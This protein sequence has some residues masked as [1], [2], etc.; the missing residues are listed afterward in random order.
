VQFRLIV[1]YDG[2]GFHGW[3][4]QP[5]ERT[6]QAVL[7]SA[8]E[9]LVG[10]PVRAVAAGRTDAGVHAEGQVVSFVTSKRF[11][12]DVVRRALNANLPEDVAVRAADVVPDSF[13]A[14]HSASS[15]VYTYRIWN[16]SVPSPF[17]RRHA[18]QVFQP[19]DLD[20]MSRAAAQLIGEH[21]FSSFRAAD[22]DAAHAVRRVLHSRM[23]RDRELLCYEIEATA[24]LRHMVR[25]IVG[26]L[27]EVGRGRRSD[28]LLSLLVLRDRTRAG[29]TAPAHGLCL[30]EVRY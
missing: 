28:D 21:D 13:D 11:A 3:Q 10:H 14:R 25:N 30:R 2:G 29:A 27:A 1:E 6:V 19:L 23:T 8:I 12:P 15:R 16:R 18:W 20:A 5:D 9:H 24:F 7:G 4:V 22:C 26:T 17:W